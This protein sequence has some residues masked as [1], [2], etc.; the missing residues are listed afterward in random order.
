MTESTIFLAITVSTNIKAQ[1]VGPERQRENQLNEIGAE[2]R[3]HRRGPGF[4][5]APHKLDM[6]AEACN[7][8]EVTTQVDQKFMII[9]V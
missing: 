2:D 6:V 8:L 9:T 1:D 7:H 4:D 3:V 5:P